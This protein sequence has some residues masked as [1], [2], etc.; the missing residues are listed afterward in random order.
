MLEDVE[1]LGQI[2]GLVVVVVV[3]VVEDSVESWV[4][5]PMVLCFLVGNLAL[6]RRA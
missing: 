4:S 2:I 1:R 6:G 3:V 5:F